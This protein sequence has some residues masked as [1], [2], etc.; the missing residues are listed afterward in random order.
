MVA[1]GLSEYRAY[2]S[3]HLAE[4][5]Y[6]LAKK[7]QALSHLL[8]GTPLHVNNPFFLLLEVGHFLISTPRYVAG[9]I[10]LAELQEVME[11]VARHLLI[12]IEI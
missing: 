11:E 4:P 1:P 3:A 7:R 6:L 10:K 9:E 2:I 8:A 5:L 12:V